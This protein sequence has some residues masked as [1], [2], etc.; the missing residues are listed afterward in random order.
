MHLV[1]YAKNP[2]KLWAV[3]TLLKIFMQLPFGLDRLIIFNMSL[4]NSIFISSMPRAPD[5]ELENDV[6]IVGDN[7]A[8]AR[9]G[10]CRSQLVITSMGDQF[11]LSFTSN[12][13]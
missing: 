5:L 8:T 7:V 4:K 9:V 10:A 12:T 13:N 3:R 6:T 2:V 11:C 1:E